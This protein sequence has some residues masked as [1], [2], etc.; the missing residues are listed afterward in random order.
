MPILLSRV[1]G[2]PPQSH[3]ALDG[4]VR[5]RV[6]ASLIA[7]LAPHEGYREDPAGPREG[8]GGWQ[9][10][11]FHHL[12]PTELPDL[13]WPLEIAAADEERGMR[14]D[15]ALEEP[16]PPGG[17]EVE[18]DGEVI[19]LKSPAGTEITLWAG[20]A[21]VAWNPGTGLDL[22]LV[23]RFQ[24]I[25]DPTEDDPAPPGTRPWAGASTA[26]HLLAFLEASGWI[27][28]QPEARG[29]VAA[30]LQAPRGIEQALLDEPGVIEFFFT[31]AQLE[32]L[33]SLW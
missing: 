15:L 11:P 1:R 29:R 9:L 21:E 19:R 10:P 32:A 2:L 18:L 24:R 31:E 7:G 26:G 6:F 17:A 27:E 4:E 14:W 3:P 8:D 25:L 28:V 22:E 20:V 12:A 16:D 33:L 13:P 30:L 23:H 5:H